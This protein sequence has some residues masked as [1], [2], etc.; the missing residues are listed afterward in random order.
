MVSFI[1]ELRCEGLILESAIVDGALTR[2][3]PVITT[4]LLVS[5]GFIPMAL[6]SGIR[7]EVQRPLVTVVIGGILS[8]TLL[9]LFVLPYLYR[10]LHRADKGA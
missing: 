9:S 5:I 8:S 2:L 7:S 4:A 3:W 6:N 1:Q 10:M